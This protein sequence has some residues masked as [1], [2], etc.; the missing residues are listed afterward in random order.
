MLRFDE[1]VTL[2]TGFGQIDAQGE[3][4]EIGAAMAVSFDGQD[5]KYSVAV[6]A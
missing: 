3:V 1:K 4:L 5:A 6:E 2:L